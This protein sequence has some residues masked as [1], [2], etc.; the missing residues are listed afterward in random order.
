MLN[1]KKMPKEDLKTHDPGFRSGSVIRAEEI[2]NQTG[3]TALPFN[4]PHCL[5]TIFGRGQHGT[6]YKQYKHYTCRNCNIDFKFVAFYRSKK[7]KK[8]HYC[9]LTNIN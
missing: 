9:Q 4:C 7:N 8:I 5:G 1:I 3:R 6:E 2:G